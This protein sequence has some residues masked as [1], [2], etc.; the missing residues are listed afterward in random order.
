MAISFNGGKDCT[1]L[2]HL[3]RCRIDKKHGPAAKIQAFHILCGDEFSEMAD[4]IR[5]AGRKYNLD[6][7]ELNGP[8]KSGLEQLKIRKPKV[9]AVFMGSRFT[10]PN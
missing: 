3:L 6:T 2:L 5:D 7:S 10:D 9:V 1:A 4:F 8:M